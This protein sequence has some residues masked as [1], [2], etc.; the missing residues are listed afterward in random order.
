LETCCGY[1]YGLARDS[2]SRTRIFKGRPKHSGHHKS[3]GALRKL[4]PYLRANRFQGFT[5]LQR[6][7]NSPQDLGRR[8]RAWLRYRSCGTP[9]DPA[10]SVTRFGNINPIPFRGMPRNNLNSP[11]KQEFGKTG[12]FIRFSPLPLGP[13]DPCSTAVHMEPFS[14]LVLK[15]LT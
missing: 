14:S 11:S 13:T 7:D 2:H 10:L 9:R 5:S 4:S 8:L 12:P 6:K 15:G 3:R 1:G